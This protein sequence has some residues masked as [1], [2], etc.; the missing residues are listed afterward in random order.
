MAG[1]QGFIIPSV[2]GP[3]IDDRIGHLVKQVSKMAVTMNELSNTVSILSQG[4]QSTPLNQNL[5]N[6]NNVW[7]NAHR[8]QSVKASLV[9][10]PVAG[11]SAKTFPDLGK[12]KD[13]A[14]QNQI[15]VSNFGKSKTGNT[16]IHCSSAADRDKLQPLLA[17]NYRD[18]EIL[19]LK[20]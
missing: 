6:A 7:S 10:K 13:I 15:Q 18:H 4:Y 5:D 9:I 8:T 3:G 1:I 11:D 20:E 17:E 2:P 19:P 12:I 14:V 16:F